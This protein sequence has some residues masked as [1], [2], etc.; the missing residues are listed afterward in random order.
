MFYLLNY[1]HL[2]YIRPDTIKNKTVGYFIRFV[3]D[4]I[5]LIKLATAEM[6]LEYRVEVI[7]NS[8]S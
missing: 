8:A 4:D 3:F 5:K 6:T 2:L 1:E 7:T